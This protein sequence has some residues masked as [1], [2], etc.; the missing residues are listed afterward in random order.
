VNATLSRILIPVAVIVLLNAAGIIDLSLLPWNDRDFQAT[1]ATVVIYLVWSVLESSTPTDGSRITL[2]AV[3]LVSVLDSF[4]LRLTAF[5]GFMAVRWAGVILL[6]A[7][8]SMRLFATRRKGTGLA[9]YGRMGQMIGLA[10]GLGSLA[11]TAV[12]LF[13]G[14]PSALKEKAR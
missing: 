9:G 3:L 4:L 8:C 13:P 12:S 14:I 2:Y 10:L 11:G 6:F 5:S 1:L 7:G